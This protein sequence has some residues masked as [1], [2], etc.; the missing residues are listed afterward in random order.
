MADFAPGTP[1]WV[2]L[3]SPA[4]DGAARFYAGLLDGLGRFAGFA[5]PQGATFSVMQM[6]A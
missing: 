2:E 4:T 3:F 6:A 5:D 1:C